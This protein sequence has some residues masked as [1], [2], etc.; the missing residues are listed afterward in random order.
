LVARDVAR[1]EGFA[2][3]LRDAHG[4]EVEILP[5]D[6]ASDDGCAAVE[7]RL[8]DTEKP[9]DVLVNNAGIGLTG[10]FVRHSIDDEERLLRLNVRAVLRLTHATLQVMTERGR[11]DVINVSSV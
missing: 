9:V 8:S 5:A 6:L 1:L 2:K 7:R 10:S 11:G 4:V 3:E